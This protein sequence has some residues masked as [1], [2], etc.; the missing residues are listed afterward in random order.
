[1]GLPGFTQA[2]S[3]IEI[4][5]VDLQRSLM[6]AAHLLGQLA[7]RPRFRE[8]RLE[9]LRLVKA[10]RAN[11]PTLGRQLIGVR[12]EAPGDDPGRIGAVEDLDEPSGGRRMGPGEQQLLSNNLRRVLERA[13]VQTVDHG[14]RD[15]RRH[16]EQQRQGDEKLQECDSPP[17]YSARA[18]RAHITEP[19]TKPW[20]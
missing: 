4:Y 3:E 17:E 6:R 15:Q 13:L 14:G 7:V 19:R 9:L 20:G 16:G 2:G 5:R 18:R 1:M 11:G 12:L 8:R 10:G